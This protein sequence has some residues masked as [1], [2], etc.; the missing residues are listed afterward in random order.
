MALA[1]YFLIRIQDRLVCETAVEERLLV[2][3]LSGWG[4]IQLWQTNG[5]KI[6]LDDA[7]HTCT[8]DKMDKEM[9]GYVEKCETKNNVKREDCMKQVKESKGKKL[10]LSGGCECLA[11]CVGKEAG[12]VNDKG[13]R[14]NAK[15]EEH[16]KKIGCSKKKERYTKMFKDCKDEEALAYST[17][18][19]NLFKHASTTGCI[20]ARHTSTS[21]STVAEH[22]TDNKLNGDD[23]CENMNDFAGCLYVSCKVHEDE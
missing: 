12:V 5:V 6:Q 4:S 13:H 10:K 7:E 21:W 22:T 23:G 20:G 9:S 17:G 18:G 2:D 8:L 3:R 16:I 15:I 14:D 1:L 11:Q 19:A